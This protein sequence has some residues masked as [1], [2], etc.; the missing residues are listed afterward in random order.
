MKKQLNIVIAENDSE[1][2]RSISRSLSVHK[3]WTINTA[4]DEEQ[5]LE[6]A[7]RDGVDAI[8]LESLF[9]GRAL[10]VLLKLK[11]S[12][13]TASI[14]VLVVIGNIGP[15]P[16][17]LLASGAHTCVAQPI[18]G[19]ELTAALRQMVQVPQPVT[20][21]PARVIE[22]PERMSVLEETSLLDAEPT[23]EFDRITEL[24]AKVLGV[25]VALVSLVDKDR[26]YFLSHH[27]L[28]EP[29]ATQRETP[30]SHS[31]CQWVVSAKEPLVVD[32]A[33]ED[34]VLVNNLAI[35]NL[36]VIAYAGQPI[37]VDDEQIIGSLC[38]IDAH[39][40]SWTFDELA[41]LHDLAQLTETYIAI[42]DDVFSEE[43]TSEV[44]TQ[45]NQVEVLEEIK[46][47]AK[48]IKAVG[49]LLR[50]QGLPLDP[51]QRSML[52]GVIETLSKRQIHLSSA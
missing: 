32:D 34:P 41:T 31:F 6:F 24:A 11:S 26:Q 3:N 51:E 20:H 38:A 16:K 52:L 22:D 5:L 30:L 29:W 49:R 33:R 48:G 50:R 43:Q 15:Q 40:R 19:R 46:L 35:K 9:P 21:A 42:E 8:V 44:D 47:A 18:G 25:P 7:S 1:A 23:S 37:K 4:L 36:G 28:V 45:Q 13:K 17:E 27:G 2:R 39:P 14:P 12:T 10:K